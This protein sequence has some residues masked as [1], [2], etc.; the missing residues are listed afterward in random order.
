M[1]VRTGIDITAVD[2]IERILQR[3]GDRFH[4]KYFSEITGP[5]GAYPDL[6]AETYAGLWATKEAAFKA[7]G[8]GYRWSGI[9]VS[10][11]ASGRPRLSVDYEKARLEQSPVPARADWDCSIAHDAGVAIGIVVCYWSEQ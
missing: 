8:R 10:Y 3:F 5:D 2:R 1:P 4:E 6:A 11:E 9:H 7:I